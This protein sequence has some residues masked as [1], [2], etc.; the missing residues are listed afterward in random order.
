MLARGQAGTRAGDDLVM[1]WYRHGVVGGDPVSLK[2]FNTYRARIAQLMAAAAERLG[3]ELDDLDITARE[4]L[5]REAGAT[6]EA[7]LAKVA[8]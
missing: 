4:G 2:F 6:A 3:V 5:R 8:S 1:R 7:E